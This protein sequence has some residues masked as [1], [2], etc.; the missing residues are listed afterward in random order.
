MK[1]EEG[2]SFVDVL[3]LLFIT[4]KLIGVINWSRWWVL[5]PMLITFVIMLIIAIFR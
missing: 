5:S 4:L 3:T 1:R 2:I